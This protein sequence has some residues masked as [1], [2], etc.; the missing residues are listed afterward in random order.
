MKDMGMNCHDSIIC[1]FDK[2]NVALSV[3]EYLSGNHLR[4]ITLYGISM[5]LKMHASW[6]RMILSFLVM[7][8]IF[9]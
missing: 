9:Q 1:T 8:P 4:E 2:C 3:M 5:Y 7:Q 6:D